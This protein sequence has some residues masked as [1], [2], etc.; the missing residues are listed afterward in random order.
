MKVR[1]YR[2]SDLEEI[3]KLWEKHHSHS[4]SLPPLNPSII[5]CVVEDSEGKIVAFGNL[6]IYAEAVMI[7]DHD[8]SRK[9]LAVA[10]QRCMDVAIM[11]AQKSGISEIHAVAQDADFADVLRNKYDFVNVVGEHLVREV[12]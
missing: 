3:S 2:P 8:R 12:D 9:D 10:F 5:D 1:R 7:M 6:K 4:F 11:G